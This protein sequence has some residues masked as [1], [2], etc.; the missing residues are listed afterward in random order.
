MKKIVNLI[1]TAGLIG[2]AAVSCQKPANTPGDNT[3]GTLAAPSL[4]ADPASVVVVPG[5]HPLIMNV[6]AVMNLLLPL[7]GMT[8]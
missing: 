3:P 1:M 7:P 4:T 8:S 5:S 6:P 2:L